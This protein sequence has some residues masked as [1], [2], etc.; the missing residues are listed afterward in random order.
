MILNYF[1]HKYQ[2][3]TRGFSDDEIWDLDVRIAKFILPRLRYYRDNHYGMP[4]EFK[5]DEEWI[6]ILD[7][8][9]FSLDIV[10]RFSYSEDIYDHNN[11]E[12]L[13][14]KFD[15]GLNNFST[16]LCSLWD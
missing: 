2:K 4:T 7:S 5:T 13:Q 3:I 11:R 6:E 9:I 8:M 15:E 10:A 12:E 16:Y 14:K 1:K